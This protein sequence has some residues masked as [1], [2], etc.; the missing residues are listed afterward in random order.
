MK[1]ALCGDEIHFYLPCCGR[2]EVVL[3]APCCAHATS[4]VVPAICP[5]CKAEYIVTVAESRVFCVAMTVRPKR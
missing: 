3:I 2:H 1:K 5:A 4:A